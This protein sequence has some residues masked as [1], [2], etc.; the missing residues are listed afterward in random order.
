MAHTVPH[1]FTQISFP[2]KALKLLL[3]EVKLGGES[4]T[5]ANQVPALDSDDEVHVDFLFT[6]S[7]F[8]L[9]GFG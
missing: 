8:P 2:L 9:V 6:C 5:L 4:A 3:R 1:E 7:T